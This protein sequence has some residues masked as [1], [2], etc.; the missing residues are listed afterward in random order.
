MPK[1]KDLR[2]QRFGRLVAIEPL[3]ERKHGHIEWKCKCDCGN[4]CSVSVGN[5]SRGV[6]KSCGCLHRELLANR[7]KKHNKSYT[8]LYGVWRAM[9]ARC[10]NPNVA[11]YKDYGGRGISICEEWREDFQAF[12]DWAIVNGYDENA[13]RKACT[14]DRIDNDG[15]YC[16]ENC[17]WI[18]WNSQQNNKNNNRMLTYKGETH[19][20]AEWCEITGISR[21]TLMSRLNMG[22]SIEDALSKPIDNSK[23]KK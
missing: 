15:N 17:R 4:F 9:K 19:N 21:R 14:I 23:K 6:T 8:R 12:Y 22:W 5:L 2:G 18:D 7:N 13:P 20:V 11:A 1:A 16:P 10:Y 3:S